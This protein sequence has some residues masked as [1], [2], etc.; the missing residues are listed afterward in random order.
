[1]F[2]VSRSTVCEAYDMLLAEGFIVARQ[3]APTRVAPGLTVDST[4]QSD[5]YVKIEPQRTYAADFKTG[6]PD[7]RVFPRAAFEQSMKKAASELSLDSFGYSGAQGLLPLREQISSYLFRIRGIKAAEQDIFIT[8]GATHA[9]HVAAE[10]LKRMSETIVIEDPCHTGMLKTFERK[11]FTPIPVPVDE[12]GLRTDKLIG[13]HGCPVY[14]T[15]SHQFPLGGILSASRRAELIRYARDNESYIIEDDYDS[16]FRYSG[17]PV[18]PL[19]SMSPQRVIYVG[20]FSKV[21]Y[22]ALRIG[23]VI[24]PH[25]L[26]PEWLRARTYTDVQNPVFEQA[27]LTDFFETRRLDRHIHKMRRLYG[28]R[29]RTLI[30]CLEEAFG[31]AW[32]PLGDAAGLHI[33]VQLDGLRV[34]EKVEAFFHEQGVCVSSVARYCIEKGR[35]E[36]KLL[37][38]YGHLC[39]DEIEDG[40]RVLN[41]VMKRL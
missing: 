30:R 13:C 22:P 32:R 2:L 16:E 19:Y 31:T 40:V 34:D 39:E 35:H 41:S 36:D 20:T 12:A 6:Q 8:A 11:G 10:L 24:L 3:G 18:A 33:A 26:Q 28:A 17:E 25:A 37:L 5:A 14:V 29:R 23:F 15:P 27:A 21:L 38:G 1:M 4:P 7:L 9:L